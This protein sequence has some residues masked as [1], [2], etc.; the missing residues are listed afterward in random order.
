MKPI[1]LMEALDWVP[2]CY[3]EE[4]RTYK[5]KKSA[6]V[7]KPLLA[8]ILA[9]VMLLLV[10]CTVA[11]AGGMFSRIFARRSDQ[12]LTDDQ[13]SYIQQREQMQPQAQT[14]G[15]W[16]VALDAS[17]SD[18]ST[19]YL[20]FSVTAPA[21]VDLVKYHAEYQKN[22]DA[23]HVI[24]GN[25]GLGPKGSR[26]VVLAS[27]GFSDHEKNYYWQ[28]TCHWEEDG[29]G[30]GNTMDFVVELRCQRL[31]DDRPQLLEAPFGGEITFQ[32]RFFG[33]EL[34]WTD[35]EVRK[36]LEN[37]LTGDGILDGEAAQGLIQETMLTEEEWVFDVTFPQEMPQYLELISQP[38]PVQALVYR[39]VETDA[40]FDDIRQTRE[41][42]SLTSLRLTPMGATATYAQDGNVVGICLGEES[43]EP[44]IV[45]M[46]DGRRIR[47]E[48]NTDSCA[49]ISQEP[50]LLE[51]VQEVILPDGTR[52]KPDQGQE[53]N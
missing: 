38:V 9:A 19:G 51:E 24:P 46:N 44:L 4:A 26:P 42:I 25:L 32:A 6:P 28:E 37:Q 53:G 48:S 11:Y 31:Y 2:E 27:S 36:K 20:L 13:V 14:Q 17:F 1:D 47:L 33:F 50:I 29:D 49:W 40:M 15:G 23:P 43:T 21:D 12:A 10:G 8:V 7:G 45:Q 3:L 22:S 34:Q 52:L 39:S 5:V 16:T 35:L 30:R 18:G 41:Q